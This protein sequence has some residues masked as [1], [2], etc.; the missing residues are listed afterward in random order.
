MQTKAHYKTK[1]AD[2]DPFTEPHSF[3]DNVTMDNANIPNPKQA[4]RHK[5]TTLYVMLDR[6]A[7]WY[8]A[9]PALDRTTETIVQHVQ[10]S[11]GRRQKVD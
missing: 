10:Q 9:Y 8:G 3:G 6:W 5:D 7:G 2:K 1:D 4:G 11:A